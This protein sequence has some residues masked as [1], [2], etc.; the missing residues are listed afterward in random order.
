MKL[1]D[2]VG[3]FISTLGIRDVFLLPGGGCMH[4]VDSLGKIKKLNPICFL[5]EQGAAIAA[6]AYSQYSNNIGV[7]LVT[8]GPGG[9][10]AIT[11]IAGSWLDSIPVLVLS[12]QVKRA[13]MIGDSKVRQMGPQEVEIV[14]MVKPI[15]K[16]SVTVLEPNDIRYHLE[17][18]VYLARSGRPGPVW[19]DI[20]LDVQGAPIDETKLRG[21][22]PN[23]INAANPANSSMKI[24][25]VIGLLN[26]SKRPVLLAGN[27]IRLAKAEKKFLS[28]VDKL[29]IPVLTTWKAIDFMAEDHPYYFG[30]PGSIASRGA[31]FIQQNADFIMVIGARMDLAQVGYYYDKFARGA[32][33]VIV[34]ID[35]AELN[36][37][38]NRNMRIDIPVVADAHRFLNGLLDSIGDVTDNNRKD[39]L[40]RCRTWKNKYPVVQTEYWKKRETSIPTSLWMYCRTS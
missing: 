9:T 14:P 31:N 13:D 5:H 28:L 33:K 34:D 29:K 19:V 23:E 24:S 38:V 17:K 35:P 36:K 18:A 3:Q 39:W 10:N 7:V 26:H 15:T 6:D 27:G 37:M 1:S 11:G 8:T 12:G 32:K 25:E 22:D 2:Y 30:R 40:S 20:P 16:Y 21:F 4:L